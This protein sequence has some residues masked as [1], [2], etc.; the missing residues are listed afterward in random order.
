[1]GSLSGCTVLDLYAGSGA[2]GLEAL[3]RGAMSVDFVESDRQAASVLRRNVEALD[4]PSARVHVAAVERWLAPGRL[5]TPAGLLL[6]DPPYAL[7]HP[8]VSAVLEQV[9]HCALL[10]D[11]ALVV[12]ERPH[13]AGLF[14]WPTGFVAERDRRYGEA[15]LWIARFDSVTAC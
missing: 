12:V 7:R 10:D 5:E 2:L 4:L 13:R 11:H 15:A 6:L 14:D 1:M 3:S 8:Q 9:A